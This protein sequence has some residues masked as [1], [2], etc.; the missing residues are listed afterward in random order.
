MNGQEPEGDFRPWFTTEEGAADVIAVGFQ[1]LDLSAEALMGRD[2]KREAEW[3]AK[4]LKGVN[5]VGEYE[6]VR[7]KVC[8]LNRSIPPGISNH[9]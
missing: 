3:V 2:S 7:M 5:K 9:F 6:M 8:H 4:V 1:E